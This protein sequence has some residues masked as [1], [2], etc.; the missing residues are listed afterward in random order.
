MRR[1]SNQYIFDFRMKVDSNYTNKSIIHILSSVGLSLM[2]ILYSEESSE[3]VPLSK[4][5]ITW[6][7]LQFEPFEVKQVLSSIVFNGIDLRNSSEIELH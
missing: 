2:W 3:C 7:G 6:H 5:I 1:P 4:M